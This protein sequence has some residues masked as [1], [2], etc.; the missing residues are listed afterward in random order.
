MAAKRSATDAVTT[1]VLEGATALVGSLPGARS[2]IATYR[3]VRDAN[4]ERRT[5]LL[6]AACFAADASDGENAARTMAALAR[7]SKESGA[8]EVLAAVRRALD[9]DEGAKVYFS[10]RCCAR[11]RSTTPGSNDAIASPYS[12]LRRR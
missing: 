9:D 11:W 1:V 4:D 8:D 12:G 2:A 3:A 6:F 7:L 10:A 5:E